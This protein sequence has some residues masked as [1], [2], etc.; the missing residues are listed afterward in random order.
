MTN[1]ADPT[2]PEQKHAVRLRLERPADALFQQLLFRETQGGVLAGLDPALV[3][4]LLSQQMAG[5]AMTY[6][7]LYPGARHEIVECDGLSIG[8]MVTDRGATAITLVDIALLADRRGRGI[9][10]RLL[11]TLIDE[12]EG[13][14]LPMRLSIDPLNS[15][16]FR[17]YS[18]L[19][20]TIVAQDTMT[21]TMERA[22][23]G[24]P[25][26]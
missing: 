5:R 22:P 18:R 7:T 4:M 15:G 9:G 8:R 14:G 21:S 16:A 10:T 6:A 1:A 19:G 23:A 20:F 13:V 17:L 11:R 2:S 12:A 25:T 26:V 3:E 24:S